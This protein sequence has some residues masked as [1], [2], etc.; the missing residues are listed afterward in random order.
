M[1]QKRSRY[2]KVP[3]V[4]LPTGTAE[5]LRLIG[6]RTIPIVPSVFFFTP[7]ETDRLDLLA[8]DHYRDPRQ[9][10]RIADVSD[11]MDPFDVIEVGSPLPIPPLR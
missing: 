7:T 2:R 10:F 11:Q 3:V 9:F 1:I 6:L 4:E 5:P 8:K